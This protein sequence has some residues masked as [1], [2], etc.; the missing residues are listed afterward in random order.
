[1]FRV[2]AVVPIGETSNTL[3]RISPI[4]LAGSF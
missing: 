1:M 4:R 2:L 3:V